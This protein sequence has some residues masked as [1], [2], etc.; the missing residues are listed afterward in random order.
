MAKRFEVRRLTGF[1]TVAA[2]CFVVLYLPIAL[3][4]LYSFN[5]GETLS[6]WQGF[7]F[8]WYVSAWE[9][10][11][12]KEAMGRSLALAAVA[13]TVATM[14]GVFC[15]LATT[16]GR[17]WKGQGLAL[18]LVN[19]PLMVPEIVTAVGLL[20]FFSLIKV[21]TGYTGFAYLVI[22]HAAFCIPFAYMPVRAR[23]KGMDLSLE[24][25]GA[26]L[27]ARP[28]DVFRHIT[29]PQLWPG[30]LSGWMLAFVISLDN[31]VITE[32]IKSA[33]QETLPTYMLGQLRRKVTPEIN[34]ISAA[35]LFVSVLF[36]LGTYY[37]GQKRK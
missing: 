7:S 22:A 26:D 25:A 16:R 23:L 35:L 17:Q 37:L 34:A 29:L 8:R 28:L 36:V 4:V 9:N 12:V 32:F 20:S 30:L 13:A 21:A 33:G 5:A 31:V 18:A 15:A 6:T 3:L 1:N 10:V 11:Q 19:Q 27:Y 2:L 14:S 24:Q